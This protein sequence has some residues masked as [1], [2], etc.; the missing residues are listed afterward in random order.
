MNAKI[1]PTRLQGI[2]N[3]PSSKSLSHRYLIAAA[4]SDGVSVI[5]NVTDSKDISATVDAM[6]ALGAEISKNGSEL[7]VKGIF[8]CESRPVSADI[9]CCESGSTLRFIIPIAAALGTAST[10]R[11]RGKLPERPITPYV[12]EFAGKDVTFDYNNTMPFSV[13][14]RL[15]GGEYNLE[16]DISSQFIT[17]LLFALP[18]CEEDSI[19]RL[20]SPLQSAPYVNMTIDVLQHFGIEIRELSL[21]D[22]PAFLI[23]GNQKYIAS[24][25]VVEGDYSQ[26]AFY[27]VA[28][29]MGSVITVNNLNEDSIQGD[30]EIMNIIRSC[31]M[32]MNPFTVDV[33]DIPDLV[34]ILTVL[35]SFTNGVSRIVNAARLRIK[36]SDRLTAIADA[37]NNIGGQVEAGEDSLTIYPI[38]HFTGGTVDACNDHRIVMAAAIAAT[39]SLNPVTIIGCEAVNKSYPSFFDDFRSLGGE[40]IFSE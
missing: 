9:D 28:N 22:H 21:G 31:G 20:T 33:G 13:S 2:V 8:S 6:T 19:I 11:G 35:G 27:Y 32:A 4:L 3:A 29:A 14:G 37:L 16:G 15:S 17:G 26:A 40:V 36:E 7:T 12:R 1:I 23:K 25:A 24:D 34:P 10:F 5:R 39:R 38:K 18:L 30:K